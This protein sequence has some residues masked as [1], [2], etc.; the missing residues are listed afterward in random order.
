MSPEQ[1]VTIVGASLAGLFLV[2]I[3]FTKLPK[4]LKQEKFKIKWRALQKRCSDQAEWTKLII[5]ADDLLD[6]ALKKKRIKGKT[7]GERLVAVQK[8]FTDNDS[9]WYA[10]K[11]RKKIDLDPEIELK[12]PEVQKALMGFLQGLKDVGAL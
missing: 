4:R 1:I 10:H 8:N 12:K 7:M 5:E 3:I 2:G 11:L 6:E 9:V